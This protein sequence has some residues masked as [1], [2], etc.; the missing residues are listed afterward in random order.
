MSQIDTMF[1]KVAGSRCDH[2]ECWVHGDSSSQCEQWGS[3][4]L[5]EAK[6]R[7]ADE[8][9]S[10][11]VQ[12][13]S[14]S[15]LKLHPDVIRNHQPKSKGYI[16]GRNKNCLRRNLSCSKHINNRFSLYRL[17]D[18][19][20]WPFEN[21]NW[22]NYVIKIVIQTLYYM[23]IFDLKIIFILIA[24]LK[25]IPLIYHPFHK[26]SWSFTGI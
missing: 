24:V 12:E 14:S 6:E 8:L 7:A 10:E 19:W 21:W 25:I 2:S 17:R 16:H 3:P 1:H 15:L 4:S 18:A 26:L 11:N 9:M 23:S 5:R 13:P 22:I 20:R